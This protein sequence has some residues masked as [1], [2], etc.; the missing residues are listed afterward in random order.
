MKRILIIILAFAT[1][2]IAKS[3]NYVESFNLISDSYINDVQDA[4]IIR[5]INGG[6]VITPIFDEN[7]P[8]EFKAPF[9]YA[10]KI[11]EEY[12]PPCLPLKVKV[13]YGKLTGSSAKAISKVLARSKE[14]FGN[15][16]DYHNVQMSVIKGVILS[17]FCYNST[18]TY[19]DSI[20]DVKFLIND[21]DIEITYNSQKINEISFSLEANPGE[22]YD[23]V[24]IAIR[25][26]LI[27]LGISSSYRYNPVT[28]ELLNPSHE[29]TPFES[30]INRMLGNYN[31]PKARLIQATKGELLLHE[32]SQS[33]KLYAPNT[34]QNGTS[35][36]YFIPQDDCCI[37][38]ILSYNFCKGMVTRALSDNYS[39]FIFHDLLG[40]QANYLTD[41]STSS[42]IAGGST[43]LLMPYNGTI[44]FNNTPYGISTIINTKPKKITI[45]YLNKYENLELSEYLDLFHPFLYHN[46]QIPGEGTSI[47]VLKKDG[48]WDLVKSN[49]YVDDLSFSMSD[50]TFNYDESQYARTID[51]YLRARITTKEKDMYGRS[52]YRSIFFVID[53]LPQ[54]VNLSYR[55]IRT[56]TAKASLAATSNIA[57]IYFSN[58]EGVDRIILEKL[59]QGSRVPSKIEISDIKKGY[60]DTTIDKPTTFTA[61][62]YNDNGISRGLGLN[63]SPSLN[64]SSLN[65]KLKNNTIF[66]ESA[67]PIYNECSYTITPLDSFQSQAT[68]CG[69]SSGEIDISTLAEG[70]YILTITDTFSGDSNSFKFKK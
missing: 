27:G 69:L 64:V 24:S 47:A 50:W 15:S 28:L 13:S 29:F 19:L 53:Y 60:F 26:L 49:S 30:F 7:C 9:S 44:S 14:N 48:S 25:D 66:I 36:N 45:D 67:E 39:N 57:R 4:Q 32:H 16:N 20:P 52:I 18:V 54:K 61:V 2:I 63:I 12:M 11:V 1:A 55:F 37:S 65:I 40:W 34:W 31:N 68:Q 42:V 59:R 43:S 17:E 33:L 23:F 38:N 46:N 3:D 70:I 6:T 35:L 8:E 56:S 5:K 62:S 51:G 10:C 58:T 22:N 21:P 41:T